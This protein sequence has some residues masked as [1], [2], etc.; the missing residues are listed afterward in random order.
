MC[1]SRSL[2]VHKQQIPTLSCN[3]DKHTFTYL[4]VAN[5]YVGFLLHTR[6][7]HLAIVYVVLYITIMY[8]AIY[9]AMY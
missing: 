6:I 2:H 5:L 9:V 4:H 3:E 7:T 1:S 8:V